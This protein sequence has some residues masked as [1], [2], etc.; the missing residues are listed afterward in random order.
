MR[1][2]LSSKVT[3]ESKTYSQLH[4]HPVWVLSFSVTLWSIA[5]GRNR[6]RFCAVLRGEHAVTPKG[7]LDKC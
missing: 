7:L 5:S 3:K 2:C 1:Q 6:P 4:S